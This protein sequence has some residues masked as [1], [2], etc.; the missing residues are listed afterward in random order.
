MSISG[1]PGSNTVLIMVSSTRTAELLADY[2]SSLD[3]RRPKAEWGRRMMERRLRMY[4]WW[5]ARLSEGKRFHMPSGDRDRNKERE[6]SDNISDALKKKDALRTQRAASRRRVR[7][8]GPSSMDA[9]SGRPAQDQSGNAPSGDGMSAK[10][11][12][13]LGILSGE[14]EMLGEAGQIADLCVLLLLIRRLE[15]NKLHQLFIAEN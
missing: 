11:R 9:S 8:G 1:T 10:E 15:N 5:K 2:L 6:G 12:E 4:L 7:G 3:R 14:G 13:K